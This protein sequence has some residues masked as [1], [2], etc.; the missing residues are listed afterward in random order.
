MWKEN[1]MEE[2]SEKKNKLKELLHQYTKEDCIVA[3]SGGVDS[4]LLLKAACEQAARNHTKVYAFTIHTALHPM[5]EIELTKK[6]AAEIGAE[7][8][9]LY[10]DELKEAG[11]ENNPTNRCYLCKRYMFQKLRQEAEILGISKI[12]EGTNL[13]DTLVYRPG[14]KALQELAII[15]PLMEACFTKNNV[16]MLAAEYS[17]P[18]H[19][20]PAAPCMATRFPYD[21]PLD[22]EIMERAELAEEH[23]RELGF[24][25]VRA[26][27]HGLLIRIEVDREDIE[28][29][30]QYRE[31]LI[32]FIKA[33]DF[34]YVSIDL[35]GFRSGSQ[36]SRL[37]KK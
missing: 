25:N 21:T 30:L 31:D 34:E 33:L 1:V 15:S 8:R 24:Y 27:V 28:K 5:K 17:I 7:H 13:D 10:V 3:F 2:F 16:R 18:V 11:I 37:P 23:I 22:Y 29:L 36:D 9:I 32:G 19:N 4:T 26:R 14:I 20:K 35:E 12:L 6:L